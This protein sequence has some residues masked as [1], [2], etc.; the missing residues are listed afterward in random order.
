MNC[1]INFFIY[2]KVLLCVLCSLSNEQESIF[3][4]CIWDIAKRTPTHVWITLSICAVSK[5]DCM[6]VWAISFTRRA[7]RTLSIGFRMCIRHKSKISNGISQLNHR[8]WEQL[9][10]WALPAECVWY[11][12]R[13]VKDRRGIFDHRQQFNY[14]NYV[15]NTTINFAD[16]KR[17]TYRQVYIYACIWVLWA[18]I[19]TSL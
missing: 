1:V 10:Y 8:E 19:I 9:R 11:F 7:L 15:L 4:F 6:H 18:I 5:R 12:A 13:K 14:W 2:S 3:A 17:C 16:N